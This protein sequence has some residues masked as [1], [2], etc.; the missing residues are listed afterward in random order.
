MYWLP[1]SIRRMYIILQPMR[2]SHELIHLAQ[3]NEGTLATFDQRIRPSLIG[4]TST[5]VLELIPI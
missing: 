2:G 5:S 4:T 1:C 3:R